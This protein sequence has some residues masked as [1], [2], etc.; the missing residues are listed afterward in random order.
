[1]S[2]VL[3]GMVFLSKKFSNKK[4]WRKAFEE[5]MADMNAHAQNELW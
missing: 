5:R 3:V 2:K 1:M 4:V